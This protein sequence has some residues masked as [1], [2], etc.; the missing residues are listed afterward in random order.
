MNRNLEGSNYGRSS[1]TIAHFRYFLLSFNS[2]GEGVSEE[3]I[4]M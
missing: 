4:K 1:I 2:F 3:K